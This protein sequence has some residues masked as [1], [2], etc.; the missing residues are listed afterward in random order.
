LSRYLSPCRRRGQAAAGGGAIFM[1][2]LPP[3]AEIAGMPAGE[4]SAHAQLQ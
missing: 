2:S 4:C 1:D 3:I